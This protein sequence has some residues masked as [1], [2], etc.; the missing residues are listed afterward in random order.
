MTLHWDPA[1]GLFHAPASPPELRPY[2][3]EAIAKI[4]DAIARGVRRIMLML[5]TGGGKTLVAS[6]MTATRQRVLFVVPRLELIT[7]TYEKFHQAGIYDVGI[8]QGYNPLTD[9]SRGRFRSA[10]SK[11]WPGAR[12]HPLTWCSS[13]KPT[14]Y[15]ASTPIGSLDLNGQRFLSSDC[16]QRRGPRDWASSIRSSSLRRRPKI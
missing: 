7:Q 4:E 9:A 3:A 15:S 2:Q 1:D 11:P 14:P 10:P 5:P 8:I 6:T 12:S 13:M 16:Q